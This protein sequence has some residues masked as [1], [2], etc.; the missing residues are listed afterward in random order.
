MNTDLGYVYISEASNEGYNV[1]KNPKTFDKDGIFYVT[2]DTVLQSFGVKNRNQRY[3]E[4]ANI[5]ERLRDEKIQSALAHNG[6]FGELDHPMQTHKDKPLS[7]ERIQNIDYD[8]RCVVIQNP[9]FRG[10]LLEATITT[11]PGGKGPDLARDII[12]INYKP[13]FSCRA[14]ASLQMINNKPTVMVRRLITYDTVQ[15]A[16]HREADMISAPKAVMKNVQAVTESTHGYVT[17]SDVMV[18]LKEILELVGKKDVNTQ[19]IMESFEL[20]NDSLVGFGPERKNV[21]IKDKDNMIYA[22]INPN[23]KKLVDDFFASF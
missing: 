16:S 23:T 2:F 3:Y 12:G 21:I 15:Y 13:M 22:N 18:P 7:P 1:V 20:G 11:T 19:M 5:Q 8:R 10:N 9:R 4:Q 17:T 6:W 14:I